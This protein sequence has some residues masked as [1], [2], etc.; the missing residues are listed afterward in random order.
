TSTTSNTA[1]TTVLASTTAAATASSSATAAA[2]TASGAPVPTF[3]AAVTS[4]SSASTQTSTPPFYVWVRAEPFNYGTLPIPPPTRLSTN[5][6]KKSL[7]Y[8]KNKGE[9]GFPRISYTVWKHIACNKIHLPEDLAWLYFSTCHILCETNN[10]ADRVEWHQRYSRCLNAQDRESLKKQLTLDTYKFILY[11]YIQQFTKV[12]LKASLVAGDGWPMCSSH[13]DSDGKLN[14]RLKAMDEHSH[15]AFVQNHLL[16]MLELLTDPESRGNSTTGATASRC[17][18]RE[19]Q[20]GHDILDALSF[21]ISATADKCRTFIG[22]KD[23]FMLPGI[24]SKICYSKTSQSVPL[25][26]LYLWLKENLIPNPFGSSACVSSGRRLSWR[27]LGEE[28]VRNDSNFK[29]GRIA[30]NAHI[31]PKDAIKG[32]KVI[33]MSQVSK[34]TV[35]RCSATLEHSNVKIHRCHGSNLYLLTPLRSVTIQKCRHTRVILGPVETTVH[36]DHCEF[37]TVIAPCHRIVIT[38]SQLCTLHLLT[39]NQPVVLN[40]N[41]SIRLAPFHT[42][43]PRLEEHL[44]RV[45]L[46]TSYNMWDQPICLGS[47]HREVA[48]VWELMKPQHFYTFT[49]PFQMEGPTKSIPCPLPAPYQEVITHRHHAVMTWQKLVKDAKLSPDQIK[50]FQEVIETHFFIWLTENDH[51]RELEN[52]A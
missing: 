49:I 25:Q 43:Y 7:T 23:L 45:G 18:G 15:L 39:P 31:V 20:V 27:M 6:M 4:S 38:N 17:L 44:L 9:L 52:L 50:E 16:Q 5:C 35:A 8:A 19:V 1:A 24:K 11:L 13:H 42:F 37:V 41:D 29:R 46:A 32:N 3:Y 26:S 51:K 47:D 12:S 14:R 22:L 48:P 28:A 21:V 34:Q 10:P 30:T 36:V 2:T 33:F 40:G